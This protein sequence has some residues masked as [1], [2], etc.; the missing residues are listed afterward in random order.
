[1]ATI[2][3]P[4]GR[5][6][7]TTGWPQRALSRSASSRAP[8][9]T[10]D[11][12]PSGSRNFT[13]R[14]GQLCPSAAGAES[15]SGASRPKLSSERRALH[16]GSCALSWE[17]SRDIRAFP[18]HWKQGGP[19]YA[20]QLCIEHGPNCTVAAPTARDILQPVMA[21]KSARGLEWRAIFL[22]S[23]HWTGFPREHLVDHLAGE[24]EI[25][26][27]IAHLLELRARQVARDVA[28]TRQHFH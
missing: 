24:P 9:S 16:R 15:M 7:T 11:P 6:S 10:P 28:V 14:C 12:G 22:S 5:F 19:R 3:S 18:L 4:P 23:M 8:I 26:R 25:R 17:N 21:L 2:P 20:L 1:M 13:V 27:W